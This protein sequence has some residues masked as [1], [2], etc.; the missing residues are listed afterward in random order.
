MPKPETNLWN[1]FRQRLKDKGYFYTR[2]ENRSGG[3]IPDTYIVGDQ[4]CFWVELKVTNGNKINVSPHQ[5]AWHTS[6]SLKGGK[7]FFLVKHLSTR[8]IYLFEGCQGPDLLDKGLSST[9]GQRFE[10]LGSMFEA[11]RPH[12]ADIL[13]GSE[14]Q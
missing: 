1:L 3:G 2:I 12:A 11:L 6:H 13:S 8:H 10:D 14:A 7:N 9:V 5:I 4:G